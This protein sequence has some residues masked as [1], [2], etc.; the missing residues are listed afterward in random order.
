MDVGL[1]VA[2]FIPR[3]SA[4]EDAC[5][6]FFNERNEVT[7]TDSPADIIGELQCFPADTMVYTVGNTVNL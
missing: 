5:C 3:I 6:F 7:S 4:D 2:H 1:C